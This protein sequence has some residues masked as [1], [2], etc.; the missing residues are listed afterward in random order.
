MDDFDP[1]MKLQGCR[2]LRFCLPIMNSNL[3]L[4][5]GLGEAFREA[6]KVSMTYFNEPEL[7]NESILGI[8]QLITILYRPGSTSWI[9]ALSSV[10]ENC[11]LNGMG[12][13]AGNKKDVVMV[14]NRFEEKKRDRLKKTITSDGYIFLK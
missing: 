4:K 1:L 10:M 13:V 6:I 11:I 12:L 2:L 9:S 14:C 7:L 5:S 3:L 8:C